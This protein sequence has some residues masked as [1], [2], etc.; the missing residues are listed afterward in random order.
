[1]NFIVYVYFFRLSSSQPY[2]WMTLPQ[3]TL[4]VTGQP[5][6]GLRHVRDTPELPA[7]PDSRLLRTSTTRGAWRR[8]SPT[9]NSSTVTLRRSALP[10]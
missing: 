7:P 8:H 5:R 2:S 4:K 1:M 10:S 6:P 3:M 9:G